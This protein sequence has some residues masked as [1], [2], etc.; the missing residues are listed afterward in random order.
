MNA[1]QKWFAV[2]N[3]QDGS[4]AVIIKTDAAGAQKQMRVRF[5]SVAS[6]AAQAWERDPHTI[7]SVIHNSQLS[8]AEHIEEMIKVARQRGEPLTWAESVDVQAHAGRPLQYIPSGNL[9]SFGERDANGEIFYT[10]H[11]RSDNTIKLHKIQ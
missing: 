8:K 4:N 1:N 2:A 5:G 7:R 9:V 6:K 3:V 10:I 11:I